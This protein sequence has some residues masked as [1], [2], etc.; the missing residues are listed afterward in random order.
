MELDDI[1]LRPSAILTLNTYIVIQL[2]Y[3]NYLLGMNEMSA[4]VT[5]VLCL[6]C[7]YLRTST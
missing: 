6:Y 5:H 2:N 3:C 7:I 4:S 1:Y